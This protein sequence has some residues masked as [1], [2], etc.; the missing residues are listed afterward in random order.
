MNPY[1]D[2]QT[3]P[4]LLGLSVRQPM[5]WAI[6]HGGKDIENRSQ[7]GTFRRHRG[8]VAI[9]ASGHTPPDEFELYE[10]V[11]QRITARP[12]PRETLAYGAIIGIADLVDIVTESDS[13]W[14]FGPFGLVLQNPRP[15]VIPIKCRGQLGL[16]PVPLDIR[17]Q[18]RAQGVTW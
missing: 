9:H 17:V 12:V 4:P 10:A 16:W 14:F 2:R 8:P 7:D 13:P 6:I 5:A 3:C 15:L 18:I 1:L 11:I